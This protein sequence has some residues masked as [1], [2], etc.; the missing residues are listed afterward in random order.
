MR[1]ASGVNPAGDVMQLDVTSMSEY[2]PG[3]SQESHE[4]W[5]PL[6]AFP[7]TQSPHT[8]SVEDE[9][10][11][12]T[13]LPAMQ[14]EAMVQPSAPPKEKV[15]ASHWTHSVFPPAEYVPGSQGRTPSRRSGLGLKP[16]G[17]VEQTADPKTAEYSSSP[18]H[19]EH[20]VALKAGKF[21]FSQGS[22]VELV[23]IVP[24]GHGAQVVEPLMF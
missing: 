9:L 21:P 16:A 6:E 7:F 19:A 24:G 17:V 5:P 18:S 2:S 11:V 13:Y 20:D 3:P 1:S 4:A 8:V 15:L 23:T 10:S 12:T 14:V 22:Q